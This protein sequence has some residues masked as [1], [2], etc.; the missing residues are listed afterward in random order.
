M[1]SSRHH[2]LD[3][4]LNRVRK[5]HYY[6][7]PLLPVMISNTMRSLYLGLVSNPRYALG[8]PQKPENKTALER[9]WRMQTLGKGQ[10][11]G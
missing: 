7:G 8:R 4:V 1:S 5:A 3:E 9:F 2:E 6:S 10:Q 11:T